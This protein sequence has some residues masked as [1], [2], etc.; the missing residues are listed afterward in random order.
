MS[1]NQVFYLRKE[2]R[3]PQWRVI[4]ARGQVLGRMATM[5]AD[6]LRG[7]DKPYYTPH[8][9]CGDY[10]VVINAEKVVLTG[11]KWQGKVYEKHT[12]WHGNRQEI[13][14]QEMLDKHPTM[15]I[16]LAVKNM[17]PKNR[18]SSAML[19]KLKVY[20]GAEHPHVAQI[21]TSTA[22]AA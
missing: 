22:K 6:A 1:M 12:G 21:A 8:T 14:A 10:I 5:I 19:K 4:D 2:D 11:N 15:I 7:K 3:D 13:S 20:A 18:L 17:L 16:E 9:D